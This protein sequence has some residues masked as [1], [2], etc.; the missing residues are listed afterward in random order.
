MEIRGMA[1]GLASTLLMAAFAAGAITPSE[2][3]KQAELSMMVKGNIDIGID[4]GVER[5]TIEK[6]EKIPPAII[7][8]V[9]KQIPHWKFQP[10]QVDGKPVHARTNMQLRIV[11]SPTGDDNYDVV[12]QGASFSGGED[13][14]EERVSVKQ[15]TPL[16]PLVR[17]MM[18][19]GA[20]GDVYLALKIGPDGEVLDG[21]VQQVNLTVRGTDKQMQ[22]ARQVLGDSSLDLVRKWTFSVPTKGEH[23][24][25]PYWSGILP[26]KFRLDGQRAEARYGQWEAYLP[27][28][29][30]SIP[31]RNLDEDGSTIDSRCD[32]AAPDGAFT[33]DNSGPKLLTPL[34]QG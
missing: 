9:G 34:T 4:G 2:A 22:N 21:V 20:T 13:A 24:D 33:L 18:N 32:S 15:K 11:A 25:Q 28:P 7:D 23:T 6:P 1:I 3:R 31:W 30:A 17:A 14:G 10:V 26:V 8:I 16:G 29:C 19:S 27:G 12:I 5:Y